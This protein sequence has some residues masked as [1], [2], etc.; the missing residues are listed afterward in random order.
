MSDETVSVDQCLTRLKPEDQLYL[1]FK[2]LTENDVT[3]EEIIKLRSYAH[4]RF[5]KLDTDFKV[6][7]IPVHEPAK[8][9]KFYES[10]A[11]RLELI[12]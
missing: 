11:K 8:L 7:R 6:D 4:V 5:G 3:P 12:M 1:S 10:Y 9:A 2:Y